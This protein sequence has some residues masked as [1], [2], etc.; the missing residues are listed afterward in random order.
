MTQTKKVN[1]FLAGSPKCGTTALVKYLNDHQDF[2]VSSHKESNYFMHDAPNI[3]HVKNEKEYNL[4]FND[5]KGQEKVF[6]DA[7]I[8]YTHS[9]VAIK[10][11]HDYN[12]DAKIILMFRDPMAMIPSFHTQL[13]YTL[14]EDIS[15]IEQA[16]LAEDARKNNKQIPQHSRESKL[17]YYSEIAKYNK[18]LL[19]VYRYFPKTQVK[20]VLFDEFKASTVE[21]YK[22][23]LSFLD[24]S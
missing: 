4:L 21:V 24:F 20:V 23:V 18:Q 22:D 8:F 12:K 9:D 14:E 16:W 1:C 17:L 5:F 11:I 7:S 3:R 10:N 19:E 15:D 13:L 2:I 6:C